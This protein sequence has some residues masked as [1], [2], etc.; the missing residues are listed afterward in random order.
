MN[1]CH[2][3]DV[4]GLLVSLLIKQIIFEEK[5]EIDMKNCHMLDVI[6][7]FVSLLVEQII[8]EEKR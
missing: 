7:L 5:K 8:F 3:L 4:I 1:N 6:G 2:M